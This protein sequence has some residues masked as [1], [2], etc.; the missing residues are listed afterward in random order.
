MRAVLDLVMIILQLGI[1]V[2]I[3]QA[4]LSWL[5]AFNVLNTSNQ[6][7]ASIWRALHQITEPNLRPIRNFLPQTGGIDLAPLVLILGIF[8]L[9]RVID[10]YIYPAFI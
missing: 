1:W 4:I 6:L 10:Y 8:F 5:I 7:V 2:L 3:I 9:Q